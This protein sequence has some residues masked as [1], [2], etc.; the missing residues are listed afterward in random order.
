METKNY[1][2][3]VN[4]PTIDEFGERFPQYKKFAMNEGKLLYEIIIS[5]ESFI[6]A[7]VV[8]LVLQLPALTAVANDCY[9]NLETRDEL[10]NF[11]TKKQFIGAVVCK[12]MEDNGFEKTGKKKSVPVN[13]FTKGEVYQPK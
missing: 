1:V 3:P 11:N 7:R 2:Y 8:T 9:Q 6:R 12:L 13:Y 5:P 4:L 10:D